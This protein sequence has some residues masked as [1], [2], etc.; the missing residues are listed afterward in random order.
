[1]NGGALVAAVLLWAGVTLIVAERP[2]AR[3]P[4]LLD[5]L[6]PYLPGTRLLGLA[7]G[8]PADLSGAVLTALDGATRRI[9]RLTGTGDEALSR[10]LDRA[11][12]RLSAADVR[13]RQVAAAAAALAGTGLT[14]VA[15]RLPAGA[16]TVAAIAAPLGAALAI[17]HAIARAARRWQ[18]RLVVEL[19]PA[20]EHLA[21]LL[22]AGRSLGGAIAELAERGNGAV[23]ADLRR[24]VRRSQQGLGDQAALAEWADRASVPGVDHLVAIL[25]LDGHTAHL[26]GLIDDEARALRAQLR[27][28][29]TAELRRRAQQ[30]WVPVTVATLVPG[31][32][33]LAVPFLAALRTF[34]AP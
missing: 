34:A 9:G 6:G 20:C 32:I 11:H 30:V 15:M 7:G 13:V 16:T 5:R 17:D 2:W 18:E 29:Q 33:L 22:G 25:A 3:R 14:A 23:A 21:M 19:P 24:V 26:G 31:S 4:Q 12:L 8:G 1:M 27:R 28:E 10:R